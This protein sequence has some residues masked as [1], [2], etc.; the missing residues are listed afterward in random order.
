MVARGLT[1]MRPA[2]RLADALVTPRM[3]RVVGRTGAR[4]AL[5]TTCPCRAPQHTIADVGLIG[6]GQ[7][8]R[9]KKE[10][11]RALWMTAS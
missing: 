3:P 8:L 6:G 4:T 10:W 11:H 9:A 7:G 5:V 2:M 1:T